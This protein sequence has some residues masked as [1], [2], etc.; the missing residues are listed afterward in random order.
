MMMRAIFWWEINVFLHKDGDEDNS[1]LLQDCYG[2]LFFIL[3]L[4]PDINF[5]L[6]FG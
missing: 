4:V 1:C 2:I 3:I 5:M 6:F